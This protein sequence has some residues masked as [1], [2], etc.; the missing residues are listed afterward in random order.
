MR[1][2][3]QAEFAK[4]E[5]EYL[6]LLE[7][8]R[9][10]P[11]PPSPIRAIPPHLSRMPVAAS[12]A[13]LE[14]TAAP[15]TPGDCIGASGGRTSRSWPEKLPAYPEGCVVFLRAL[16][17]ATSKTTLK[18]AVNHLL[19]K[20][21]P[22]RSDAVVS[23]VDWVKGADTVRCAVVLADLLRSPADVPST[24]WG[25][26]ALSGACS[27]AAQLALDRPIEPA[28]IRAH[29]PPPP[30]R[31]SSLPL[32]AARECRLINRKLASPRSRGYSGR[33]RAALLDGRRRARG[34]PSRG[35]PCLARLG[36]HRHCFRPRGR[37][38][39]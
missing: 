23:Y 39:W 6:A 31:R 26:M 33:A 2:L 11:A 27:P 14:S 19:G 5:Q 3:S 17:P 24:C 13:A 28:G 32:A 15:I 8:R 36:P 9:P 4:L 37:G 10:P 12:T 38:S 16:D 20:V 22:D 18:D 1:A 25:F 35:C 21:A 7:A 29:V 30:E 34:W